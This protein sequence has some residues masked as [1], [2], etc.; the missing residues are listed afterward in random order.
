MKETEEH[1]DAK[2][3]LKELR[4]HHDDI[5]KDYEENI[6]E[7]TAEHEK[8]KES[9]K[10]VVIDLKKTLEYAEETFDEERSEVNN[11]FISFYCINTAMVKPALYTSS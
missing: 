10:K 6:N 1:S 11:Q 8:E 9:L 3:Q 2:Q 5:I 4:K 7:T